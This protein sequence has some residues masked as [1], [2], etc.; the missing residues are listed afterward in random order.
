[1]PA[2][3]TTPPPPVLARFIDALGREVTATIAPSGLLIILSRTVDVAE[4][5]RLGALNGYPAL[6]RETAGLL[7]AALLEY[8]GE[9]S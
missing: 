1:M 4:G 9:G 8:A 2:D 6:D 7:G 5:E 3:T